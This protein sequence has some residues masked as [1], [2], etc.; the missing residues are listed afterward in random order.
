MSNNTSNK[1][2]LKKIPIIKAKHRHTY[3]HSC[4]RSHAVKRDG[5]HGAS[6]KLIKIFEL[7]LFGKFLEI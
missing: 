3:K 7:Y 1:I 5:G 6:D 4:W 2:T